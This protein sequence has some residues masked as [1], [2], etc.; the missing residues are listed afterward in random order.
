MKHKYNDFLSE[1]INLSLSCHNQHYNAF[2]IFPIDTFL[3]QMLAIANE[4]ALYLLEFFDKKKLKHEIKQLCIQTKSTITIGK[5]DPIIAI[6]KELLLYFTGN[7]KNF[8]TP[9]NFLGTPFQRIVWKN[10]KCIPYGVTRS[11][12]DQAKIIGKALAYRAVANA[13]GANRLA[14]IIPCHRVV[15]N[16]G[17]LGG[18]SSGIKRKQWLIEHE[19]NYKKL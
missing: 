4:K 18:Y 5:T 1:I 14:I 9:I 19:K 6:E 2:K 15:C 11:Y 12:L 7:L 3:G 10:L 16:D 17:S 13:N 8:E